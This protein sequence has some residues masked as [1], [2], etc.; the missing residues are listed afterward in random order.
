M[1]SRLYSLCHMWWWGGDEVMRVIDLRVNSFSFG[2]L[3]VHL[4]QTTSSY[5]SHMNCDMTA[6]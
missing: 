3:F 4:I 2:H 5:W 6:V 1:I